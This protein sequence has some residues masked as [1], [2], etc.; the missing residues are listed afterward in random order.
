MSI[1]VS[2]VATVI[3][4][5]KVEIAVGLLV[6]GGVVASSILL[7]KV[8]KPIP[9][10]LPEMIQLASGAKLYFGKGLQALEDPEVL[11]VAAGYIPKTTI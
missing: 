1:D 5:Y 4:D 9:E 3:K 11:V 8:V 2:K 7:K 10:D 6:V